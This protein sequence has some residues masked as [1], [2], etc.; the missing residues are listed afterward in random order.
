[1]IQE[2][3]EKCQLIL[4]NGSPVKKVLGEMFD[5]LRGISMFYPGVFHGLGRGRHSRWKV[6][7]SKSVHTYD[8]QCTG[9]VGIRPVGGSRGGSRRGL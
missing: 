2:S 9:R 1:M 8:P 3:T 6:A 7:I 5:Y 4:A